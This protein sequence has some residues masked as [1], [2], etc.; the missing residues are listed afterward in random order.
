[1][2]HES[3]ALNFRQRHRGLIGVRSKMPIRDVGA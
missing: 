2:H 1:M 3:D